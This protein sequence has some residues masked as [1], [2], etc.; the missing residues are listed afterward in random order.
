MALDRG[1]DA[2]SGCGP[3]RVDAGAGKGSGSICT[4]AK[5]IPPWGA[6]PRSKG[7]KAGGGP[8]TSRSGQGRGQGNGDPPEGK[9]KAA[10]GYFLMVVELVPGIVNWV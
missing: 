6:F 9:K 4:S 10:L 2:A 1:R 7:H 3:G 5:L 8:E